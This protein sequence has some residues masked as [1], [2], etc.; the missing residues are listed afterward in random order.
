MYNFLLKYFYSWYILPIVLLHEGCHILAGYFL[1]FKI[2]D[3]KLYKQTNPPIFNS[4]V[5]FKFRKYDWKWN[6]VLYSPILL[7]LPIIFFF[8]HPILMYIGIYFLST[9]M[10]FDKRFICIFLPSKP[11]MIYKRKIEYY[12]YLV[13]NSSENEFNYFFKRNKLNELVLNK[14]LLN[15]NEFFF[16]KKLNNNKNKTYKCKPFK[17]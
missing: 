16:Q 5:S 17:K 2:L 11:D 6:V 7:T 4:Y 8:L 14:H 1:G 9:I 3:K 13:E 12:S 15:E 10:Y